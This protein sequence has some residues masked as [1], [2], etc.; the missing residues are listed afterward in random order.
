[1]Y[2]RVF[3][4]DVLGLHVSELRGREACFEGEV[5]DVIDVTDLLALV[6]LVDTPI[7]LSHAQAEKGTNRCDQRGA[8][9]RQ[10]RISLIEP[11]RV[12]VAGDRRSEGPAET[13][14]RGGR[15]VDGAQEQQG[16][17]R[18]PQQHGDGRVGKGRKGTFPYDDGVYPVYPRGI[19]QQDQVW[20]QEVEERVGQREYLE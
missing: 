9:P 4:V 20:S 17:S 19:R 16:R 6:L 11:G 12:E 13:S 2:V 7:L 8:P 1:M 15:A 14:D 10:S 18:V 3:A 5:G